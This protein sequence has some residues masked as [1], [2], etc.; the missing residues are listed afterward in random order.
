MYL[1][2]RRCLCRDNHPRL[3]GRAELA[4]FFL[5]VA[6]KKPWWLTPAALIILF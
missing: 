5:N 6:A 4:P 2:V 3:S 1:S